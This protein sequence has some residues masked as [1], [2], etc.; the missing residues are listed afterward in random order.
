[1]APR[2]IIYQSQIVNIVRRTVSQIRHLAH[3]IIWFYCIHFPLI[4]V[5]SW[6]TNGSL[7][8]VNVVATFT[9]L[10]A[11]ILFLKYMNPLSEEVGESVLLGENGMY[12][13]HILYSVGYKKLYEQKLITG[14]AQIIHK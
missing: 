5:M 4:L 8:F 2:E 6:F 13:E 10:I 12:T 7:N 11:S 14:W 9:D 3:K 1:M